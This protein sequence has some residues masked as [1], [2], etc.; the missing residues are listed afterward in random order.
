MLGI[1]YVLKY[2]EQPRGLVISNWDDEDAYFGG[3]LDFLNNLKE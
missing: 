2:Q 1:E 3:V